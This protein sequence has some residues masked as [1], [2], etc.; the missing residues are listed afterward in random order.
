MGRRIDR[1]ALWLII[2][3][4]AYAFFHWM[5]GSAIWAAA[6]AAALALCARRLLHSPMRKFEVR[7][8]ARGRAARLVSEWALRG[9]GESEAQ[10]V[11]LVSEA[12]RRAAPEGGD[13]R[14]ALIARHESAQLTPDDLLSEYRKG[15][16][17]L[18]ILS[19]CPASGAARAFAAQREHPRM[20][21]IDRGELISICAAAD[22][23][24]RSDAPKPRRKFR[25]A[26]AQALD[27]VRPVR[28]GALGTVLLA[29]YAITGIWSYL[30]SGGALL[31]LV[32]ARFLRPARPAK[33]LFP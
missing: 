31:L 2:A 8:S 18:V 20:R 12:Y 5:L 3:L 19:T 9:G 1:A 14:Y 27:R 30:V 15:G 7:R 23:P 16:E 13:V 11:K 22:M 26:W 33:T 17:Y 28:C 4:A 21:L 29:L 32:A 6:C 10:A 25:F 24:E